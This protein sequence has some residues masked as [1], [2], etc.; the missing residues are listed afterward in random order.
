MSGTPRFGI[1][2]ITL[3]LYFGMLGPAA[4]GLTPPVGV[5]PL[6]TPYI[7]PPVAPGSYGAA[8]NSPVYPP[9]APLDEPPRGPVSAE[10]L[11]KRERTNPASTAPPKNATG[12]RRA[13][14]LTSSMSSPTL[15]SRI[16]DETRSM[17]A[18]A[19]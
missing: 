15:R 17:P 19:W 4:P 10:L 12:W 5:P 9:R 1:V 2:V 16:A 11:R 18:A 13:K 8:P 7:V 6:G 14:S 3:S